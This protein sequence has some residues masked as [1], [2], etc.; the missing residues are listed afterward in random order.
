MERLDA[1][2]R[3]L[4]NSM[5]TTSEAASAKYSPDLGGLEVTLPSLDSGGYFILEFFVEP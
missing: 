5:A 1:S 2:T 4:F 3:L